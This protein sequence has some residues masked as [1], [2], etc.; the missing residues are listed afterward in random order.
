M[1]VNF[2]CGH[3]KQVYVDNRDRKKMREN[4]GLCPDCIKANIEKANEE[5]AK[6]AAAEGFPALSGSPKQIAW[7]T[8]IRADMLKT[9][10]RYATN[11]EEKELC[12]KFLLSITEA[13]KFIN[14]RH[15]TNNYQVILNQAKKEMN[16]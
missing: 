10:E 8:T 13:S 3:T 16:V 4:P 2:S 12:K 15:A 14:A 1:I 7:A 6:Q 11:D 9:V 5:A